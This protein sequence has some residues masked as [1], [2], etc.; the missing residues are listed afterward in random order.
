MTHRVGIIGGGQLAWMMAQA[1]Q[2]LGVDLIVQTPSEHDPAV[3]I[4]ESVIYASVSNAIAT[5]EMARHCEVISFENEFVD[6]AQLQVLARQGV[7]FR[8]SLDALAP[9]LDKW[10]QLDYLREL[11]LPVPAFWEGSA[12]IPSQMTFPSV[13]KLRR[14]GYDGQGTFVVR[15]RKSWEEARDRLG[16]IPQVVEEFVPF[17]RELAIMAGRGVTGEIALYPVVESIQK[18]QVC[19]WTIAPA[20]LS[21]QTVQKI[22]IFAQNLLESLQ[23]VGV[24]GIEFFETATG[25]ILINEIA[26]RTH[27]SGHYTLDA[28]ETSQ[29]EMQ[30]RAILGLP[31]GSPRLNALGAIMVNLLGYEHSEQDY[32][33]K[34]QQIAALPKA[35]LHWYDKKG[36]R[37]GRKLGHVTIRLTEL[38]DLK[39]DRILAHIQEIE[40]IWYPATFLEANA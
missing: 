35:H 30:L 36:S 17:K 26:P 38:E 37:L 20:S 33:A 16:P 39:C 22:E 34:R 32:W 21:T 11:G 15:D 7:C 8:P 9:L 23:F 19:R 18:N 27:N 4:A 31:L 29:F 25:Q 10:E 24:M 2:S 3:K 6:L 1:A 40:N 5:A 28:C 12:C 13:I 14:Q